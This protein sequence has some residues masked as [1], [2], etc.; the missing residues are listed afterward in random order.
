MGWI[1]DSRIAPAESLE[2]E[3]HDA[4]MAAATIKILPAGVANQTQELNEP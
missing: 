3:S 2:F 1:R 4:L